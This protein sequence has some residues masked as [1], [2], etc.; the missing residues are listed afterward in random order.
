MAAAS[1]G[2]GQH[3]FSAEYSEH[4]FEMN[5]RLHGDELRMAEVSSP[6]Q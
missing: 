2:D 6:T 4:A 1:P 5:T 3:P